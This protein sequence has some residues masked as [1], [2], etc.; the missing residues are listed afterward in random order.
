MSG[1]KQ[2][3]TFVLKHRLTG[4]IVLI[5]FTVIILPMLLS[6]PADRNDS[7][8][9]DRVPGEPDPGE[10]RSNITPIGGDTPT[11]TL[12]TQDRKASDGDTSN[13]SGSTP[14]TGAVT[15]S[16][17]AQ[18][19]GDD[20]VSE[21]TK[22]TGDEEASA[23]SRVDSRSGESAEVTPGKSIERG[24]I[25]QVGTFKNPVNVKTLV[26]KLERSGFG[27][28][29]TDVTTSEGRA[30]RV[31]VGPFQTRVEAAR[32]KTRVKHRTGSQGFIVAYP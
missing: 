19:S 5:G 23:A 18:G 17:P 14:A 7:R 26:A 8:S 15:Q 21:T 29:T 1:Q 32:A 13:R 3:E 20:G 6:G 28:S 4:A 10:F 27:S 30:T 31:W 11:L 2:S 12:P 22:P 25:V 24:W 16:D 9:T